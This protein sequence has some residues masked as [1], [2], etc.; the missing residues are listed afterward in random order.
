MSHP[1]SELTVE[2]PAAPHRAGARERPDRPDGRGA[3]MLLSDRLRMDPPVPGRRLGAPSVPEC[4]HDTQVRSVPVARVFRRCE[5]DDVGT[6]VILVRVMGTE[7]S[8]HPGGE[9]CR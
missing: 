7:C 4:L 3:R 9:C 6:A 2:G 5:L 1:R 8:D